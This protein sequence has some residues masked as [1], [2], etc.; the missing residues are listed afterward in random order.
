M[1][2]RTLRQAVPASLALAAL[3]ALGCVFTDP[4]PGPIAGTTIETTNG[5]VS[6]ADGRPAARVK[7]FLIDEKSWLSN[8]KEEKPVA[9]DS[10]ETDD[11]GVFEVKRDT[12]DQVSF[13]CNAE[14]DGILIRSFTKES[15]EKTYRGKVR[16]Q[17]HAAYRGRVED[18]Q[19]QVRRIYLVGTPYSAPIDPS[20]EFNLANVPREVY[21][22]VIKR[23]S[24]ELVEEFV[25]AGSVDLTKPDS[26]PQDTLKPD[27][28]KSVLLDDF[29]DSDNKSLLGKLLTGGFWDAYSDEHLG[30][31]AVLVSPANTAPGNYVNAIKNGGAPGRERAME[32]VYRAGDRGNDW[33]TY[34]FVHLDVNIG[35]SGNGTIAHY[36]LAKMDTLMFWAKGSGTLAVD[37]IQN[38]IG[39]PLW[40]TAGGTVTL[41]DQWQ[42][43]KIAA[44]D[45]T[46]E[47]RIFPATPSQFRAQLIESGLPPYAQKPATYAETGG[48]FRN[49]AFMGTG[50]TTFWLDDIR[51]H[52][53][54]L[55][56]LLTK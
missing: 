32:I 43:F 29:E 12:S 50:G 9:L 18:G 39:I 8:V 7:V 10:F 36:N 41:T 4:D 2:F 48:K 51:F 20:G 16:M 1:I 17:K 45:M 21:P 5:I 23:V 11:K 22:V 47:A 55:D 14:G 56:D 30:G 37:L 38:Q 13:L 19:P 54:A 44:A 25:S 27:T 15:F 34:S 28:S 52:G 3:L 6:M 40:V 35:A 53:P 26:V 33:K 49:I 46:V 24:P 42:H 31:N